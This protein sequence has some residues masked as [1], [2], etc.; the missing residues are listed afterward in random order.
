MWRKIAAVIAGL[1]AWILIVTVLNWGLRAWLPGYVRAEPEMLFTLG[2]QTARLSIGALASLGA[3]A[4]VRAIAPTSRLAPWIAGLLLVAL[5]VPE[6]IHVWSRFPPWYH[7]TF[8]VTLA[9]LVA[10]GA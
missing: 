2:M 3:G 8:L 6:H 4:V 10:L 9:P 7:L 1:L 5:F